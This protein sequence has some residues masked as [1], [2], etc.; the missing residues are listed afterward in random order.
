MYGYYSWPDPYWAETRM[1]TRMEW[2]LPTQMPAG[3]PAPMP[4]AIPR[5]QAVP[6]AVRWGAPGAMPRR[7]PMWQQAPMPQRV[8]M[9][10]PLDMQAGAPLV[11]RII[12]EGDAP[13]C[14]LGGGGRI[15][16]RPGLTVEVLRG[17]QVRGQVFYLVMT[18]DGCAGWI[19]ARHLAPEGAPGAPG[20]APRG[21]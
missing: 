17:E 20:G 15:H 9:P 12:G 6:G 4:A 13:Q 21:R 19:P 14:L 3:I 11:A 1:P 8:P 16:Y 5:P 10:A 7:V 2:D 18:T